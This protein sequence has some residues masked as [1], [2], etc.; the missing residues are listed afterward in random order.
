MSNSR[1]A[2]WGGGG[3][4]DLYPSKEGAT[5][6]EDSRKKGSKGKAG[7]AVRFKLG[8]TYDTFEQANKD[9]KGVGAASAGTG[10]AAPDHTNYDDLPKSL[11]KLN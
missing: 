3:A 1:G 4:G 5:S 7:K 6:Q 8:G 2:D 9:L 11:K 10:P